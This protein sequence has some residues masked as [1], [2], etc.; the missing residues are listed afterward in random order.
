MRQCL[1][2]QSGQAHSQASTARYA[3]LLN[4]A[5]RDNI[6]IWHD[7]MRRMKVKPTTS[8]IPVVTIASIAIL[9]EPIQSMAT[10][11][12]ADVVKKPTLLLSCRTAKG[13]PNVA[14]DKKGLPTVVL[15]CNQRP[16]T[17]NNR[18]RRDS[19]H[20]GEGVQSRTPFGFTLQ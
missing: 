15:I 14:R 1:V 2:K 4:R 17:A 11:T 13:L 16:V 18:A 20:S 9:L 5:Y 7:W 3:H 10:P 19:Q 6:R 12:K 8:F